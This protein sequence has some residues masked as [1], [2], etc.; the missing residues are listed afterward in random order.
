MIDTLPMIWD[1]VPISAILIIHVR[2]FSKPK[3]PPQLINASKDA[4]VPDDD[5]NFD[6]FE[7]ENE[8]LIGK[9]PH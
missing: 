8:D 9:Y 6:Y 7:D 3:K 5:S 4:A 1:I 2:E